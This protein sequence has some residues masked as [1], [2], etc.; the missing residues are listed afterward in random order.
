MTQN[1]TAMSET[2]YMSNMSPQRPS[3][4]RGI[5]KK[6]EGKVRLWAESNDS[7]FVVTGAILNNPVE[8]IG[9]NNVAVPK[10]FYKTIIAFNNS[11][12][13]GIAFIIPNQKSNESIYFYAVSIDEVEQITGIDFYHF[14]DDNIEVEIE[15]NKNI[16]DW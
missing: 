12:I 16:K 10:E 3:F 11:K 4:N 6:L 8:F 7:I 13:Q 5:W 14:L 1:S 2:F 9:Y 15:Q